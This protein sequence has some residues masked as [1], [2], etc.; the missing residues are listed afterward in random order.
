MLNGFQT[1]IISI[2]WQRQLREESLGDP[3]L[4]R[5]ILLVFETLIC[6]L[7]ILGLAYFV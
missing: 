3:Q 2:Q 5:V 1:V 6:H 7:V 4:I